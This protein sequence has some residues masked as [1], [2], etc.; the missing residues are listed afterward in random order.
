VFGRLNS[1]AQFTYTPR[2]AWL[3][4]RAHRLGDIVVIGNMPAHRRQEVRELIEAAGAQLRKR[5]PNGAEEPRSAKVSVQQ[6][7][8]ITMRVPISA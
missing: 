4:P 5:Q 6:K 7:Q 1:A 8:S 2:R 3:L